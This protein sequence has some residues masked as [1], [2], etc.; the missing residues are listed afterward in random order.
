MKKK[1]F[2]LMEIGTIVVAFFYSVWT[3]WHKEK[4]LRTKQELIMKNDKI[5]QVLDEFLMIKQS[6]QSL[7]FY[8]KENDYKKVAIY[9]KGYLG[10]RLYDELKSLNIEVVCF[11][12]KNTE[13]LNN[14]VPVLRP[15]GV[16]PSFDIVVVTPVFYF[17]MIENELE[18]YVHSPIVS[19]EDIL[20]EVLL[21][22]Y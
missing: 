12:D 17:Y 11:I 14:E 21:A 20:D 1:K 5:I 3:Y 6:E 18:K 8:F 4:E 13:N 10:K 7:D 2:M 16:L 22:E 15:D 19:L 9:G